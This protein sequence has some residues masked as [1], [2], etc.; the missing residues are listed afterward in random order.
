MCSDIYVTV[1]EKYA[2]K[3]VGYSKPGSPAAEEKVVFLE[4]EEKTAGMKRRKIA[5]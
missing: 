2:G 4:R 3:V 1:P 5:A